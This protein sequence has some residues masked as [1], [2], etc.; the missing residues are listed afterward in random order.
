VSTF[1]A[2]SLEEL[3]TLLINARIA[4]SRTHRHLAD[5]LGIAEHQV[6]RFEPTGYRSASL[7]RICDVAAALDV[8]VTE[9]A[10]LRGPDA[11]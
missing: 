2:S 6:Q 8:A 7:A 9:Q 11:G 3:A 10:S 5:Q 4:R 1:E